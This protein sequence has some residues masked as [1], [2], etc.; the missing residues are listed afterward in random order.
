[1]IIRNYIANYKID[2]TFVY[3]S[4]NIFMMT[5]EVL[6]T[7]LLSKLSSTSLMKTS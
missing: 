7:I 4:T 1:M 6:V 3:C 2:E 5:Y